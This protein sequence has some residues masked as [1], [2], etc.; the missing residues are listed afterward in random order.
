MAQA[1][2][3]ATS[4]V[5]NNIPVTAADTISGTSA[6]NYTLT[7]PTGLTASITAP[8]GVSSTVANSI[9]TT[10]S[11]QTN[12]II[13]GITSVTTSSLIQTSVNGV[14]T[15]AN[16]TSAINTSVQVSQANLV[17]TASSISYSLVQSTTILVSIAPQ[18]VIVSGLVNVSA[19]SGFSFGSSSVTTITTSS[20]FFALSQSTA[21]AT[22]LM[23]PSFMVSQ[24]TSVNIFFGGSFGSSP[25]IAGCPNC[26]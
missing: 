19:L 7:Q 4:N 16:I 13:G 2:T 10:L 5:G 8:S 12:I 6:G 18:P 15:L 20:S 22:T 1:G 3:F 21:F 11:S 23:S 25:Y 14:G 24:L 9:S 17:P 26:M